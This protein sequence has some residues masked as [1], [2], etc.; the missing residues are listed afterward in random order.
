L[1]LADLAT[2]AG[3]G[4]DGVL[5]NVGRIRSVHRV[6]GNV[7]RIWSVHRVL[8]GVDGVDLV[9]TGVSARASATGIDFD[10]DDGVCFCVRLRVCCGV[11]VVV[12]TP[13]AAEVGRDD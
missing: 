8:G 13:S 4:V 3:L 9:Y 12:A 6:L 7:G 1:N 10:V 2:V 5:G 11:G